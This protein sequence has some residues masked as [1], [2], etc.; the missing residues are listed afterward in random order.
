MISTLQRISDEREV[1]LRFGVA[2]ASHKAGKRHEF[3]K[4]RKPH[5][6]RMK[7]HLQL[8]LDHKKFWLMKD[9]DLAPNG[10][11]AK[12]WKLGKQCCQEND[13]NSVNHFGRKG[14]FLVLDWSW[15]C[16][17]QCKKLVLRASETCHARMFTSSG[18]ISD[19]S[20]CFLPCSGQRLAENGW[21]LSF[22]SFWMPLCQ[23]DDTATK[24]FGGQCVFWTFEWPRPCGKRPN[25][26]LLGVWELRHA[27]KWNL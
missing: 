23:N 8:I 13:D 15:S 2:R 7:T 20:V 19:E 25:K 21:K 14:L 3:W 16:T 9:H 27:R 10:P 18:T 17:K 12:F 6:T 22:G 11:T 4:L 24:N 26:Q 1:F 5:C